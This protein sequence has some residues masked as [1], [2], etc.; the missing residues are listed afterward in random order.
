MDPKALFTLN[1]CVC[2]F[3]RSFPSNTIVKYEHH[4][5][6]LYNPLVKFHANADEKC[7]QGF[8]DINYIVSIKKLCYCSNI[9]LHTNNL[10]TFSGVPYDAQFG[11]VIT[12]VRA[13]D[14][15]TGINARLTYDIAA[16]T[17]KHTLGM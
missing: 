1:V 3:L 15:D 2:V 10:F 14:L 11:K 16:I 12:T 13:Y 9:F 4:H 5:L 7:E 6:L 17:S 8:N